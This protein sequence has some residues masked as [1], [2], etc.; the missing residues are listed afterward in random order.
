MA[1]QVVMPQLGESIVEGTVAKWLVKEG[2]AVEMDQP[3][4]EVSTDKVDTELPSPAAGVIGKILVAEGETV[5]VGTPLATI[6]E[7]A[8]TAAKP[9]PAATSVKPAA[10]AAAKPAAPAPAAATAK[11]AGPPSGATAPPRPAAQATPAAPT[12]QEAPAAPA[13]KEAP[14]SAP[15]HRPAPPPTGR[16]AARPRI[17]GG[18]GRTRVSPL[19]RRMAEEH[20]IDLA[21]VPGTGI[22]GRVTK[23][24]L[25]AFIEKP[26]AAQR[27]RI[28]PAPAAA[29]AKEPAAKAPAA[30]TARPERVKTEPAALPPEFEDYVLIP[31]FRLRP[32]ELQPGDEA[33]P[34]S[35]IRKLTADHMAYSNVIA[36]RVT[37]VAEVNM[38][39]VAE[40]RK[41]QKGALK[42]EGV[43][44]TYLPFLIAALTRA[45][46]EYPVLNSTVE[47]E[48]LI[49]KKAVNVGVAVDTERGLLVPVIHDADG[50][51][52]L[53]IARAVQD[54]GDRARTKSITPD[55]MMG[56]TIAVSNPGRHGN[57]FGTPV[58]NQPH[59]VILRMGEVVKRPVVVEREGEDLIAIRP[60][61]FLALT[62]DHRVVDGAVGNGCL[63]RI[64]EV[65]EE[66]EF[67]L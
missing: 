53:G 24:D 51:S 66:G 5:D 10:A 19:V 27:A 33:V 39:Q 20:G 4:L 13:V 52:L 65:L 48:T 6:E 35:R 18:E 17:T 28:A 57:L 11:R 14:A 59:V 8:V 47:G 23:H 2:D 63:Y 46:R 67:D 43:S 3:L 22:E 56:G 16:P 55:D 50:M 40:I 44:L 42:E 30:K 9:A 49:I 41:A 62:Y 26:Q 37:T 1:V 34:F 25:L 12:V 38:A 29:A 31:K 60:M 32:Y 45:L 58:I 54:L 15:T 64:K 21:Q 36:P 61:M 7:K